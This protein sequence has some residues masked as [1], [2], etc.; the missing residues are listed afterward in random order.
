M[1]NEIDEKAVSNFI[2]SPEPCRICGEPI[3][4]DG[5]VVYAGYSLESKARSA[6]GACWNAS[7]DEKSNWAYPE[8]ADEL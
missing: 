8:D 5:N 2:Y 7:K 6:H 4:D 1:D 3:G